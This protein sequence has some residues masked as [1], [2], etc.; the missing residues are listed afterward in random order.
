MNG[1]DAL[2]NS[3]TPD[4]DG[5]LGTSIT[6][7]LV[8]VL[9]H[10]PPSSGPLIELMK[11]RSTLVALALFGTLAAPLFE[12][13]AFRGFL[14]PLLVR[15]LGAVAGIGLAAALFGALHFSEYGN[16]WRSALIVGISGVSFGCIRHF[17]GSTR[18]A[19]IAHAAFNALPFFYVLIQGKGTA[20]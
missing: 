19:V 8:S 9:T 17:S 14:Q 6:V 20:S 7:G 16:S 18:A 5:G 2:R 3:A 15:S 12:E 10:M 4:R 11:D 13:L 1:P